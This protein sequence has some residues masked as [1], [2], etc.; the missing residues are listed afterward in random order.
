MSCVCWKEKCLCTSKCHGGLNRNCENVEHVPKE[1]KDEDE[2]DRESDKED[3]DKGVNGPL[4]FTK[5]EA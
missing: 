3:S 2:D 1:W 4:V 5:K